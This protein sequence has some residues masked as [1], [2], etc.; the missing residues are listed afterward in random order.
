LMAIL[1][2]EHVGILQPKLPFAVSL[3]LIFFSLITAWMTLIVWRCWIMPLLR[4]GDP[5]WVQ[6]RPFRTALTVRIIVWIPPLAAV[7]IGIFELGL[8]VIRVR[9]W[10]A[11]C[12]L[13]TILFILG[14]VWVRR[15]MTA[16]L[17][18]AA[19]QRLCENCGYDL[20]GN[21]A[22]RTCPECGTP[23][24]GGRGPRG[25]RRKDPPSPSPQAFE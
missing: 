10:I 24:A 2:G 5:Q 8:A 22:A 12:L 7:G 14:A 20:R 15:R 19:R 18:L 13:S 4:F 17:F 3:R 25:K 1:A 16:N 6:G 11:G 21:P 23:T 9:L